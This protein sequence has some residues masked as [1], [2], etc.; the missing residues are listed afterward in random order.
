MLV[1]MG[2]QWSQ[3][4]TRTGVPATQE[5]DAGGGPAFALLE[6]LVAF[7]LS[8]WPSSQPRCRGLGQPGSCMT[9][10]LFSPCPRHAA[11]V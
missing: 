10:L 9:G 1:H 3:R 6:L 8:G 11:A 2:M 5:L 4:R 7:R